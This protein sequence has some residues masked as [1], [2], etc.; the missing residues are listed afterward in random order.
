MFWKNQQGGGCFFWRADITRSVSGSSHTQKQ[1]IRTGISVD[2]MKHSPKNERKARYNRKLPK[3]YQSFSK[4]LLIRPNA[5]CLQH[6]DMPQGRGY[7]V[8]ASLASIQITTT[9]V[10]KNGLSNREIGNPIVGISPDLSCISLG[11]A[12]TIHLNHPD[13]CIN[14]V[15]C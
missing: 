1:G 5:K 8:P 7:Q 3:N 13:F 11:Y 15:V 10:Q 9:L 2:S 6:P 14:R 12:S 4:H